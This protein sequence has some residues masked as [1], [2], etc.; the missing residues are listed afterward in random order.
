MGVFCCLAVGVAEDF[1]RQAD[2]A[3]DPVTVEVEGLPVEV[4]RALEI[5][6]HA[7]G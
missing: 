7:V 5:H 2:H 6:L 4:Q 1:R 3:G